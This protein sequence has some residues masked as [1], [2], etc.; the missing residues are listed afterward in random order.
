MKSA[1]VSEH[2]GGSRCGGGNVRQISVELERHDL[3]WP[4]ALVVANAGLSKDDVTLCTDAHGA[5]PPAI[6]DLLDHR[7]PESLHLGE[8]G[9]S[10]RTPAEVDVDRGDADL[11]Q[12][13]EVADDVGFAA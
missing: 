5:S 10:I 3:H 2:Q 4:F 6:L 11:L 7:G 13:A 9:G 8:R 1:A 12:R